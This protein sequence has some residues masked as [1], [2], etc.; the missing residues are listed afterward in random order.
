MA[1]AEAASSL[2][3]KDFPKI[4]KGF[5]DPDSAVRYW[6]AMGVLM[7]GQDAV[8][9]AAGQLRQAYPALAAARR[10]CAARRRGAGGGLRTAFPA[11]LGGVPLGAGAGVA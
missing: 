7:R 10:P 11:R 4:Q 1:M 6:A 9:A 3:P 5:K 2:D 8:S